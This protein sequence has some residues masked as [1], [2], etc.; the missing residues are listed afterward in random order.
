MITLLML[1]GTALCE[2][3]ITDFFDMIESPLDIVSM[4]HEV[5]V[6]EDLPVE[7]G[8]HIIPIEDEDHLELLAIMLVDLY[9]FETGILGKSTDESV[10]VDLYRGLQQEA[11][12][13]CLTAANKDGVLVNGLFAK[14]R[15]GSSANADMYWFEYNLEKHTLRVCY[16]PILIDEGADAEAFLSSGHK[17]T[18]WVDTSIS[19]KT[20]N[21]IVSAFKGDNIKPF[22]DKIYKGLHQFLPEF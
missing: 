6:L 18:E 3:N 9:E 14:N 1:S 17:F 16:D 21:S 20:R 13:A 15:G 8:W 19:G 4:V 2:G 22:F 11:S 5:F 7:A 12:I 10:A